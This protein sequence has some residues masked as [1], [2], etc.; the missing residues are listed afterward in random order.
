MS[1]HTL[2]G[3]SCKDA[4]VLSRDLPAGAKRVASLRPFLL[5]CML[6]APFAHATD[7]PMWGGRPDRNMVAE[8]SGIPNDISSGKFLPKSETIDPKT[9]KNVRWIGKLGSQAYGSPVVAG[10]RVYVG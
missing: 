6:G 7:W 1:K 2:L 8:A 9:T 10:G 4:V 3:T 5:A